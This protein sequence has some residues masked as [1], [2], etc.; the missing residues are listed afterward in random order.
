MVCTTVVLP[1]LVLATGIHALGVS[2]VTC[3]SA[4]RVIG[5][6]DS[7]AHPHDRPSRLASA[8]TGLSNRIFRT[9]RY[10][11]GTGVGNIRGDVRTAGH[12]CCCCCCWRTHVH[13]CRQTSIRCPMVGDGQC[14]A[15]VVVQQRKHAPW[16]CL[17]VVA[18]NRFH[19]CVFH[20]LETNPSC[21]WHP[22][23][24]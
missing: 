3:S 15:S 2:A 1:C 11:A 18:P 16:W 4:A 14:V 19:Y 7:T 20:Y 6:Y 22:F 23:V 24:S 8:T 10:L 17:S 5:P 13:A 21:V 12:F 9:G